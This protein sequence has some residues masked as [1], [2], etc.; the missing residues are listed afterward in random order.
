MANLFVHSSTHFCSFNQF[1]FWSNDSIT[2]INNTEE[3]S[4]IPTIITTIM[5]IAESKEAELSADGSMHVKPAATATHV[6]NV[7]Q[8]SNNLFI[9]VTELPKSQYESTLNS[10]PDN[11]DQ[12]NDPAEMKSLIGLKFKQNETEISTNN[13]ITVNP[14]VFSISIVCSIIII[15]N[16]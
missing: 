1:S 6:I 14:S 7:P 9:P 8:L 5:I 13:A 15:K 12:E 11:F 2:K 10:I 3:V 4:T 16:L